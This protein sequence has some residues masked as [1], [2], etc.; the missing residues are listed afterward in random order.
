[1]IVIWS[2]WKGDLY[3]FC[4]RQCQQHYQAWVS[5]P[6]YPPAKASST[7]VSFGCIWCGGDLTAGVKW[8]GEEVKSGH[9]T[10]SG[11]VG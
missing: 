7:D 9:S 4:S 8:L 11:V 5:D 10:D 1:M 3:A 2:D 6:D